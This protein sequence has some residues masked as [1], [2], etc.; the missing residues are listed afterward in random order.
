MALNSTDTTYRLERLRAM[1][2]GILETGGQTFLL[3]I[4]VRVFEA[5][6]VAKAWVVSGM[7]AGLLMSPVVVALVSQRGWTPSEGASRVM[8]LGAGC[9]L[10]AAAWPVLP[11]FVACSMVGVAAMSAAT[12][13]FTQIYQDN[14]PS[15]RRGTL[16][17]RQVMIRV[18]VAAL[19][20][21]VAGTML[22]DQIAD[23]FR[24]LLVVYGLACGA[25]AWLAARLPSARL[26]RTDHG[27]R[28]HPFRA[29]SIVVEDRVFRWT[30]ICWM[31]MGFANL[32]MLPLR[33]EY[34]AHPRYK[35]EMSA[36]MIA[37]VT[38]VIPSVV[39]LVM[40]PLWGRMF[41]R[42]NFFALRVVL[43]IGFALGILAF[44]TSDTVPGLMA[45]AV[46]F[47][48]SQAG[49]A[50]AW[51]LWV[52]KFA[53]PHRVADY[54]SVHTFFTGL[55]GLVAPFVAF[56]MVQ[57]SSIGVMGAVSA[58]MIVLASLVLLREYQLGKAPDPAVT[59]V[60]EASR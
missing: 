32:M 35:L 28:T 14:Y 17:S 40:S 24:W 44:F 8:W 58:G 11:V 4:A 12:P 13:L 23:R 50:V 2:L 52:T 18:A 53:P 5:S 15:A 60:K 36:S 56:Y 43:N 27:G 9:F 57:G 39:H 47:G 31:V 29:L 46:L 1:A 7:A 33:V 21:N 34:L 25:S 3:L 19:F 6:A 16:F 48:A 26:Q 30:L 55:R 41:D 38:G 10:L 22:S 54:M 45:G 42:M 37:L 20:S 49:G 59:L 51:S